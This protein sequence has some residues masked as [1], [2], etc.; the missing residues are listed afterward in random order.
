[1]NHDTVKRYADRMTAE[2][3][4]RVPLHEAEAEIVRVIQRV[5]ATL[6]PKLMFGYHARADIEQEAFVLALKVLDRGVY[7]P[8][9]PLENFLYVHLRRRLRNNIRK[10]YYRGEPP[11]TC[12]DVSNPS[13]TPC[14]KWT[15]W[16]RRNV[17]KQ[18]LMRPIDI[19]CV[20]GEGEPG[21]ASRPV[22]GD[23]AVHNELLASID[24]R[25]PLELRADYLRMREHVLIPKARRQRFREAV[26]AII[27]PAPTE[28][29]DGGAL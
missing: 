4:H 21:M 13:A 16:N 25:L 14:K 9:R 2:R 23:D 20:D 24:A 8:S 18:N 28:G 12:C 1:V 17:S 27:S 15:D 6:A 19:Q 11:C 22:D 7:D 10:H 29:G 26:L 3:G 5:S